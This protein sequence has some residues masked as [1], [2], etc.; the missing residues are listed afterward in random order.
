MADPTTQTAGAPLSSSAPSLRGD[1]PPDTVLGD[2]R[3]VREVGRGGMGVVYEAVQISLGR[4]VALKVLPSAFSLDSRRLQRFKNEAHAAACLHHTNIVPVYGI[5]SEAGV[6][7]YAMQFVQG[8]TLADLLRDLRSSAD[9]T[10]TV[11]L[12]PTHPAGSPTTI[13]EARRPPSVLASGAHLSPQHVRHV[14]WLGLQ[15]A[16]ALQHAHEQGVLHRDV[17]PANLMVE[18]SGHLWVTDFG[19]AQ[20]QGDPGL[21]ATGDLVGTLRYMSPEQALAKRVPVDHRTDVYSLG[22]TLYELFTLQ[23]A[24]TGSD[25]AELLHN[26]AFEEPI[27][28]RRLNPALPR[29]AETILLKALAKA[30][31]ERYATAQ[32]L[33]EDLRRLLD[34]RPIQARRPTLGQRLARWARRH[35]ALAGAAALTLMLAVV[36]LALSTWLIWREKEKTQAERDRFEQEKLRAERGEE[37]AR[38]EARKA[39]DLLDLGLEALNSIHLAEAE[40]RLPRARLRSKEDEALLRQA[41]A[42]YQAF[43]EKA[44]HAPRVRAQ[45]G[46]AQ[47]RVA[48]IR[49][50]LG[51]YRLAEKAIRSAI[52]TFDDLAARHSG[53]VRYREALARAHS[54]LGVILDLSGQDARAEKAHRQCLKIR[55]ALVKQF[56]GRA[57]HHADKGATLHNLAMLRKNRRDWEGVQRLVRE[58]IA[59]QRQA[60]KAAPG[61]RVCR[62]HLHN[63]L[64]LLSN[65][66]LEL[67]RQAEAEKALTEA[68]RLA[69]ELMRIERGS[70]DARL[71]LAGSHANLGAAHGLRDDLGPAIAHLEKA[72]ALRRELLAEYPRL[73]G[74]RAELALN[75]LALGRVQRQKGLLDKALASLGRAVTL[76]GELVR[77]FPT[78]SSYR[79]D[80]INARNEQVELLR[81]RGRFADAEQALR[82]DVALAE[83][84]LR[85]APRVPENRL[86]LARQLDALGALLFARGDLRHAAPQLERAVKTLRALSAEFPTDTVYQKDLARTCL[87]Y[88]LC[89]RDANR[90]DESLKVLDEACDVYRKLLRQPSPPPSVRRRL[91]WTLTERGITLMDQGRLAEAE[92]SHRAGL[93]LQRGLVEENRKS[94]SDLCDLA[95]IL[96][97]LANVL[98]QRKEW[99]KAR[100]LLEQAVEH[101]RAALKIA[102]NDLRSL[103]FFRSHHN[104]LANVLEQMNQFREAA[105][106][107]GR[108]VRVL[109][110]R[111]EVFGGARPYCREMS[112]LLRKRGGYLL[113]V[114]QFAQAESA[115]RQALAFHRRLSNP[116][117]HDRSAHGITLNALAQVMIHKKQPAEACRLLEKAVQE[118]SA[119]SKAQPASAFHRTWL[120]R[121]LRMLAEQHATRGAVPEAAKAAEALAQAATASWRATF[122]AA[123]VLER[124][125]ALVQ[126][127]DP[128]QAQAYARRVRELRAA[129][130]RRCPARPADL[131][132][133]AWELATSPE[134]ALRDPAEA[135][136]LAGAVVRHNPRDVV[137]WNTLGI[138][139][140][141][142]GEW[143]KALEALD[144]S[145]AVR[146]GGDPYDWL[147]GGLALERLGRSREA[148]CW[149]IRSV[150]W[151][152]RHPSKEPTLRRFRA[153]ADAVFA[154]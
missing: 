29:D 32:D 59:A 97:N 130:V 12:L 48:T 66:L 53:E 124:W 129:A 106:V 148:R 87:G 6:H 57:Q 74:L 83:L 118:H 150:A 108:A 69:G 5:G 31:D 1:L 154:P 119:A 10:P 28:P 2:F 30:P 84:L 125:R 24:L 67:E 39:E 35:R 88:G 37:R 13:A 61:S 142:A 132:G 141:R 105:A 82:D 15:A 72:L 8:T 80:R 111:V 64:H 33:A 98:S 143:A 135:V 25:R 78:V 20:L 44:G 112:R 40:E 73:A 145:L 131:N 144:H 52:A 77:Q 7:Y 104:A 43:A 90:L 4:R 3:I 103:L 115:F 94:A 18:P 86:L 19:L 149:Y 107:C 101:Q 123:R 46:L 79:A 128:K 127:K 134:E 60:L 152:E 110:G 36:G 70:L 14:A 62:H 76:W 136:R 126:P 16:G 89:L 65:A 114:D 27:S 117:P 99:A 51:Q 151:M 71:A 100:A 122:A 109:E 45:V 81:A 17:K 54:T 23:P 120:V 47:H 55:R 68:L 91:A 58:A 26:I 92:R 147:F 93:K 102:P 21:T 121:D 137:T 41:L 34:D 85:R 22:A 146:G 63:H 38:Q 42:F 49:I 56:P 133:L 50:R 153:E 113:D 9:P 75:Y 139:H 140:Y 96:N 116:E 11:E 138:A 95:G